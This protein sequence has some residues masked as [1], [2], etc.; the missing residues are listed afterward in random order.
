MKTVSVKQLKEMLSNIKN[1][2]REEKIVYTNPNQHEVPGEYIVTFSRD[3]VAIISSCYFKY[4][5][6]EAKNAKNFKVESFST[7]SNGQFEVEGLEVIGEDGKEISY[8]E[9]RDCIPGKFLAYT[10]INFRR[11][12]L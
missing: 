11:V 3:G 8:G 10:Y 9:L 4:D 6:K 2:D 5:A 1:W 7:N 12:K